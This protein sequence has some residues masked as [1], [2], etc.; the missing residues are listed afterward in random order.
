MARAADKAESTIARRSDAGSMLV[1][2]ASQSHAKNAQ[3][4]CCQSNG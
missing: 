3:L 2:M 4:L 1:S